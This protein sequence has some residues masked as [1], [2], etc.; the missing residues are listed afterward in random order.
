LCSHGTKGHVVLMSM[1]AYPFWR[2]DKSMFRSYGTTDAT[3]KRVTHFVFLRNKK[4]CCIDVDECLTFLSLG[5]QHIAF[6]RNASNQSYLSTYIL[7]LRNK[8]GYVVMTNLNAS[9][10]STGLWHISFLR[11]ASN[12]S[13]LSTYIL[14]LRNKWVIVITNFLIVQ[15]LLA[16]QLI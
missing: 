14:F 9:S 8:R 5:Y 1:N 10:F 3:L 13:Y 4:A 6:L 2:W 12:Q 15:S 16:D 7:F 11:N